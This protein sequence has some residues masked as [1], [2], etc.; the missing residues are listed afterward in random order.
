MTAHNLI[1]TGITMITDKMDLHYRRRIH[2]AIRHRLRKAPLSFLWPVSPQ[3][4]AQARQAAD[5][6]PADE[7]ATQ[8]VDLPEGGT[9]ARVESGNEGR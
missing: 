7:S 6:P 3:A 5:I 9:L 4:E 2:A 1:A 8:P